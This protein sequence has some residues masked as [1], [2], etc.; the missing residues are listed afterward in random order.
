MT[1]LRGRA[2]EAAGDLADDTD[3]KRGASAANS[4]T[5]PPQ[6]IGDVASRRRHCV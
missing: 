2:K 1:E 4:R 3:R 5:S 6:G